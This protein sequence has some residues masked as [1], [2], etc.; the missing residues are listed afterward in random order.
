MSELSGNN[1]SSGKDTELT[2]Q[3]RKRIKLGLIE[4]EAME[5]A[6]AL[7]EWGYNYEALIK[8]LRW[9]L[10]E[11]YAQVVS[12]D[13]G[14]SIRTVDDVMKELDSAEANLKLVE[15][16]EKRLTQTMRKAGWL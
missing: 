9:Q 2:V 5:T 11:G 12:S 13:V 6:I 1:E 16:L 10:D 8:D 15:K 4:A 7:E 14:D 3:G